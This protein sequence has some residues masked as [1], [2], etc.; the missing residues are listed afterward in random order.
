MISNLV[1]DS[2]LPYILFEFCNEL[3]K[4]DPPLNLLNLL[5]TPN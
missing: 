4:S 5:H 1:K 2:K 3:H